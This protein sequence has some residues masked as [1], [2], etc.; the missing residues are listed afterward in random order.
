M[1]KFINV[2]CIL[3]AIVTSIIIICTFMTSY[4]FVYV[5][6]IFNSY[7]PI[8]IALGITMAIL[9]IRFWLNEHGKRKYIYSSIS[10]IISLLLILSISLV[11]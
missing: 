1:K 2:L 8:Q 11:K 4:Q 10:I 6:Q 9:A 5:G 3:S 7:M